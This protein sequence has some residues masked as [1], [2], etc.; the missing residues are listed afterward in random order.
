MQRSAGGDGILPSDTELALLSEEGLVYDESEAATS[1]DTSSDDY[2]EVLPDDPQLERLPVD[3]AGEYIYWAY[4]TAKKKRRRF[5]S[6]KPTRKVRRFT[7][8]K[9]GKGKGKGKGSR[10]CLESDEGQDAYWASSVGRK[11]TR[12]GKG[13]GRHKPTSGRSFNAAYLVKRKGDRKNPTGP[14]GKI[15]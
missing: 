11:M 1:T 10:F 15:L 8:R 3:Q 5:Q 6:H 13:R 12:K 2:D 7:K 4:R 9:G 14:D